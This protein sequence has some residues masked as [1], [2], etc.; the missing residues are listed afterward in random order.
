MCLKPQPPRDLP[1]E[2]AAWGE[3]HLPKESPYRLIGDILYAHYHDED[4][5]DLYHREGKPGL[6]PVLLV[7]SGERVGPDPG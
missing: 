6:S 7:K 2:I 5:L 1:P 4:F 3:R